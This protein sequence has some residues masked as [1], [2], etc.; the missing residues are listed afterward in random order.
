MHSFLGHEDEVL[1][2]AFSPHAE[3]IFASG[4]S[5]RRVNIWN[6]ASIGLEQSPEDEED[7]APELQFM[8]GGHTDQITD[9]AWSLTEKWTMAT[10][11]EDNVL[12]VWSP[13][14]N[15]YAAESVVIDIEAMDQD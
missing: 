14:Q 11:A 3:T 6:M 1:S 13:S 2:L 9:L 15:V 10:T 4:S 12:Q 5:D 7:G 8:H